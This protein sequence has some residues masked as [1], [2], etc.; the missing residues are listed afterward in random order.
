MFSPVHVVTGMFLAHW[1]PGGP[2]PAFCAGVI[3]HLA[4]DAIPHGDAGIGHWVD[5]APSRKIRLQRLLPMA[6]T[7]QILAVGTIWILL[8][9]PLLHSTPPW[10]LLAGAAGSVL[11]DY[12]SGFR[13]LLLHPPKWL[14]FLHRL[15]ER[16]HYRGHEPFT[17]VTGLLF[18]ASLI[19]LSMFFAF[20]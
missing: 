13:D 17:I 1:I 2:I 19:A 16:C 20:R 18:Q 9:S 15:H 7:D 6:F 10:T 3:S 14:E 11:P 4:L 5:S 8:P 12:L